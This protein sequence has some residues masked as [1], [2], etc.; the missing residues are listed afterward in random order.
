MFP[1][2][3]RP[4]AESN[5]PRAHVSLCGGRIDF[6]ERSVPLTPA[7]QRI[8]WA[9]AR[10]RGGTS[11][12]ELAKLV[13][14]DR[15]DATLQNAFNVA[16]SRMRKRLPPDVIVQVD[17]AYRFGDEIGVDLWDLEAS[18][19]VPAIDVETV[20][21]WLERYAACGCAERSVDIEADWAGAI[22]ARMLAA[23]RGAGDRFALWALGARRPDL[24][25]RIARATLER[26]ACDERACE[27]AIRAHL[28]LGDRSSAIRAYRDHE[29][30]LRSELG[31]APSN[32]LLEILR[33]TNPA[34]G[35]RHVA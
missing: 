34:R 32:E 31:L 9:L 26:D 30:A 25:L 19:R 35:I 11:R 22:E 6:G 14:P 18:H 13:W 1:S 20:T 28:A 4:S 24:A 10:S 3:F 16:L 2:P 23:I 33:R 21:T 7:E 12:A 27:F 8:V 17:G 29:R 15:D 5:R